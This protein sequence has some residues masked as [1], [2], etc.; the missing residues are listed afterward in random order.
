MTAIKTETSSWK[1][2]VMATFDSET[3]GIQAACNNVVICA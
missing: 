3:K 1:V 2:K